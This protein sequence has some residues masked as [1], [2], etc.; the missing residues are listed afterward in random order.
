M[1]RQGGWTEG[2]LV[3]GGP[4]LKIRPRGVYTRS[5]KSWPS[6]KLRYGSIKVKIMYEICL[7]IILSAGGARLPLSRSRAL[8]PFFPPICLSSLCLS[9]RP[10]L[11][12]RYPNTYEKKLGQLRRKFSFSIFRLFDSFNSLWLALIFSIFLYYPIF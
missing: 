4:A 3:R 2:L 6:H 7:L 8:R 5:H 10:V 1:D 9:I 11:V 12:C